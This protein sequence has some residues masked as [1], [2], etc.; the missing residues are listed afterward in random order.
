[1]IIGHIPSGYI[2]SRWLADK[3]IGRD[4][5]P[6]LLDIT[7]I[8]GAI[9]PDVDW[10]YYFLVDN[11]EH[12][13]HTYWTHYPI[14]WTGLLLLFS[15]YYRYFLK[16]PSVLLGAVFSAACLLHVVLDSIVGN[17]LWFA[18]FSNE[19]YAMFHVAEVYR[20]WWLSYVLHWTFSVELL[21][22]FWAAVL[23]RRNTQLLQQE[24]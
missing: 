6:R 5:N 11:Q 24:S 1:M 8:A 20:P 10:F 18:P 16:N 23:W 9:A 13:H 22:V 12:L 2:L 14:V 19:S 7:C 17:I 15:V 3:P 4:I 21:L